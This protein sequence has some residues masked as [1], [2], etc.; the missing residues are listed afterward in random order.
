MSKAKLPGGQGLE[1]ILSSIRRSLAEEATGASGAAAQSDPTLTPAPMGSLALGAHAAGAGRTSLPERIAGV[2]NGQAGLGAANTPLATTGA[3]ATGQASAGQSTKTPADA[4]PATAQG[5]SPA[6]GS[7]NGYPPVEP[8]LADLLAD[9]AAPPATQRMAEAAPPSGNDAA[10]SDPLWFLAPKSAMAQASA[11]AERT[12][13]AAPGE[14]M[15]PNEGPRPSGAPPAAAADVKLT[16]PETL[17]RSFPPLFGVAAEVAPAPVATSPPEQDAIPA[18]AVEAFVRRIKAPFFEPLGAAG[19]RPEAPAT[20][21][22]SVPAGEE[23]RVQPS[24]QIHDKPRAQDPVQGP[25]QDHMQEHVPNPS[26]DA[27]NK[28]EVLERA[29]E[30]ASE[31]GREGGR[32]GGPEPAPQPAPD[33]APETAVTGGERKDTAAPDLASAPAEAAA[34]ESAALTPA[35][36]D[37][38]QSEPLAVKSPFGTIPAAFRAEGSPPAPEDAAAPSTPGLAPL[39]SAQGLQAAIAQLLEPVL[40]QWV[41]ITLPRLVETAIREEVA[42]QI[43]K[44][45]GELKI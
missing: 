42:R 10:E 28:A 16:Q 22:G 23:H 2:V 40:R 19:R 45:G 38:A 21:S 24:E 6:A 20:A 27:M 26:A 35:H 9:V 25:A 29:A 36:G 15:T 41:E 34:A 31:G 37:P 43:S 5:A 17:R 39:P 13:A 33:R 7:G 8:S 30:P 44:R 4:G 3:P 1:D 12:P 32:E 18:S 11:Q 14:A